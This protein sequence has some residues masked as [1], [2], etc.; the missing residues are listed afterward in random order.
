ME[1]NLNGKLRK[2]IQKQH[3]VKAWTSISMVPPQVVGI[4]LLFYMS[5]F[6]PNVASKCSNM[7]PREISNSKRIN[8]LI[9]V[10]T[11]PHIYTNILSTKKYKLS[12]PNSIKSPWL[13]DCPNPLLNDKNIQL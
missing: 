12:Q 5:T 4:S 10:C 11:Y 7:Q 3:K 13:R 9:S 6:K 1:D 2:E 8:F